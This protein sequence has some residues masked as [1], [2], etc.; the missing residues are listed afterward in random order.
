MGVLSGIIKTILIALAAGVVLYLVFGP[1]LI[2]HRT[3]FYKFEKVKI[4][5]DKEYGIPSIHAKTRRGATYGWGYAQA[6]DRLFQMSL[7]RLSAYGRTSEALGP[8]GLEAD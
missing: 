3:L 8:A 1:R 5:W 2:N 6:S 7:S 4:D